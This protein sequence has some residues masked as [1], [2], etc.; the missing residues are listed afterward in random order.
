MS[1]NSLKGIQVIKVRLRIHNTY[2]R[3]TILENPNFG[4]TSCNSFK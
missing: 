1:N 2:F 3:D 4:L